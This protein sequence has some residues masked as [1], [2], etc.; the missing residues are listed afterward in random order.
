MPFLHALADNFTTRLP[1][2]PAYLAFPADAAR[3]ASA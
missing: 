3:Q 1:S 2:H